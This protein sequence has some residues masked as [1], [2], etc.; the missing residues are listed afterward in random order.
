MGDRLPPQLKGDRLETIDAVAKDT[1]INPVELQ[2]VLRMFGFR[3]GDDTSLA[4]ALKNATGSS[5]HFRNVD[6]D[7]YIKKPTKSLYKATLHKG[8][9]PS[10]YVYLDWDKPVSTD[11]AS[12]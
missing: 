10:E 11:T 3:P 4:H 5:G 12:A 2:Q 8:K 7:K 9:N 6:I 1:G